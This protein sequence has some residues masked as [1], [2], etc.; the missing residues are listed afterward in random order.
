MLSLILLV[1]GGAGLL[2]TCLIGL[3]LRTRLYSLL[4][5]MPLA[6]AA[7]AVALTLFGDSPF[8]STVTARRVGPDRHGGAGRLVDVAEQGR[9]RRCRGGGGLM[10]AVIQLAIA[11]GA[12]A[13]GVIY[14]ASGYRSTFPVSAAALCV[15]AFLTAAASRQE[16]ANSRRLVSPLRKAS[17]P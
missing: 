11:L 4:V 2:G 9:S 8:A 14:D 12:T 17:R 6:M 3:V 5:V 13:G 16:P 1:M 10:V 7:I 15:S